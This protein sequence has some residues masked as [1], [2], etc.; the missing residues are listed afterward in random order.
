[1][2]AFITGQLA[3]ARIA[4]LERELARDVHRAQLRA[5]RPGAS[6]GAVLASA[7]RRLA[8]TAWPRRQEARQIPSTEASAAGFVARL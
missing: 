8:T 5:A 6:R 1:M 4:D 3:E 2:H 7:V